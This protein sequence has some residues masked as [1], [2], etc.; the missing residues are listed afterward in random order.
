MSEAEIK[1]SEIKK[2]TVD[3]NIIHHVIT[4]QAGTITKAILELVMNSIDAQATKIE[5][6]LEDDSFMVKDNG[7]GFDGKE[8]IIELFGRFGKPHTKE[9]DQR[10]GTVHGRFRVGRGQVLAHAAVSWESSTFKMEADIKKLGLSYQLSEDCPKVDGCIVRGKLFQDTEYHASF[11]HVVIKD[12]KESLLYIPVEV[13]INGIIVNKDPEKEEW[14]YKN[15]FFYYKDNHEHQLTVYN[16]GAFVKNMG[17]QEMGVG[18]TI[19]SKQRMEVNFARNDI[20]VAKCKVWKEMREYLR[21]HEKAKNREVAKRK[22]PVH[23]REYYMNSALEGGIELLEFFEYKI[24]EDNNGKMYSIYNLFEKNINIITEAK[25]K[26]DV[27]SESVANRPGVLVIQKNRAAFMKAYDHYGLENELGSWAHELLEVSEYRDDI[28][29][30]ESLED[31]MWEG[32]FPEPILNKIIKEGIDIEEGFVYHIAWWLTQHVRFVDDINELREEYSEKHEIIKDSKLLPEEKAF[33]GPIRSVAK[34]IAANIHEGRILEGESPEKVLA[35]VRKIVIGD[36]EGTSQAWTDG[37]TFIAID[38][39]MLDKAKDTIHGTIFVVL[40]LIVHEYTHNESTEKENVH[41]LDFYKNFHETVQGFMKKNNSFGEEGTSTMF[42][43]TLEATKKVVKK[44]E[45]LNK[46]VPSSTKKLL[47]EKYG[48]TESL[49][50][51]KDNIQKLS[52]FKI[53]R[54]YDWENH[55]ILDKKEEKYN[56]L[57]N[58]AEKGQRK[59]QFLPIEV[60]VEEDMLSLCML[61]GDSFYDDLYVETKICKIL[62][63]DFVLTKEQGSDMKKRDELKK[64]AIFILQAL[65]QDLMRLGETE[66]E[67]TFYPEYPEVGSVESE[68]H[69]RSEEVISHLESRYREIRDLTGV[70]RDGDAYLKEESMEGIF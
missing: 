23:L 18:G 30:I 34:K 32:N 22:V 8:E 12:I 64:N 66:S 20:L 65:M 70:M 55:Y 16:Q 25:A 46:K 50:R 27:F 51:A 19:V 31:R 35:D 14:D 69:K 9:E 42:D 28:Y 5:L 48:P 57:L 29:D 36:S 63:D 15:D 41:G 13:K 11:N 68:E 21:T 47:K 39:R 4:H 62:Y 3:D 44:M 56:S 61:M 1:K 33:L 60:Q 59:I 37:R 40:N 49:R 52:L 45:Q 24:F 2:F 10:K 26:G 67:P 43:L 7:A 6:E 53:K 17:A 38:K 58:Q 54:K